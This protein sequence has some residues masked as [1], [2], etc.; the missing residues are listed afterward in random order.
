MYIDPSKKVIYI[1]QQYVVIMQ[2]IWECTTQIQLVECY[3]DFLTRF[4]RPF[5]ARKWPWWDS[6]IKKYS[7]MS[8]IS[9]LFTF[10]LLN[11]KVQFVPILLND[12]THFISPQSPEWDVQER[13]SITLFSIEIERG[14]CKF[15]FGYIV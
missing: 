10:L 13:G 5:I 12:C 7:N 9:C 15:L 6:Q 4:I 3:Y 8:T 14:S 11:W 2:W 1:A